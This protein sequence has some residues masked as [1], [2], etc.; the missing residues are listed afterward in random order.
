[1][2][3]IFAKITEA[4][5]VLSNPTQRADYDRLSREGHQ[6]E[7]EQ[8]KVQQVLR[9]VTAFQKAEVLARRSDWAGVE[10]LAAQAHEDDPE[11][12]EYAALLAFARTK[13][14]RHA[15]DYADVLALLNPAVAQEPRNVRIKLYR[16]QVLKQAGKTN[17]AIR[18]FRAVVE[19]DPGNVDAQRELRLY[20]MRRGEAAEDRKSE[21]GGL[22]GRFFGKD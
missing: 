5:K 18:D 2:T 9:A 13:L 17:E 21:P 4:H 22:F 7:D 6:E 20:K 16:A 12:A 10:K 14:G 8:A 3:R 11:Q 15:P 1:V 19:A